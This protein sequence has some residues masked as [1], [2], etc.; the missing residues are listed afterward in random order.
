M[1]KVIYTHNTSKPV[2]TYYEN[3]NGKNVLVIKI[4]AKH[5]F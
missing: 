3:I 5:A 1:S 2:D 4:S